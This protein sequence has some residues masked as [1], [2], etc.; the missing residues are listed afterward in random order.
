M[1]YSTQNNTENSTEQS[2]TE[3]TIDRKRS[4]SPLAWVLI[5]SG[6]FFALFLLVSGV[7]YVKKA[8]FRTNNGEEMA[9]ASSFF[10]GK[11][12]VGLIEMNGVI[13]DSKKTVAKLD[14]LEQDDRIKAVVLRLNSPG[15]AVGPSQEIYQAVKNFK[16]PLVV[17]MGTVAASGAY[18]IACGAKKVFANPGTLTGSIG[19]IMQFA[20]IQR[21]YDWA[22]I[23]R[24]SIKSGQFKD[25]GSEARKMTPEE[26]Q[27]FQNLVNDVLS[28]FK[29]AIVT[30]RSLTPAQVSAVAD[31]R[32]FS[33]NQAKEL[34][35]VDELGTLKDA[36]QEA[37]NQANIQ[38]RPEVITIEKP[39]R[40]ILDLFLD[41]ATETESGSSAESPLA[42]LGMILFRLSGHSAP[43]ALEFVPGLY[44]ILGSSGSGRPF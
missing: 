4:V 25:A 37:A 38:G 17:S 36:I 29:Q 7:L 35:L 5:L 13:M 9:S 42:Q 22:K 10:G 34:H 23:E 18:Y 11:S 40:G 33:G 32:V 30:G 28:Q 44:S 3:S 20:N 15:G 2:T 6:I 16:K 26:Q 24:Y 27:L 43:D 8:A 39:K 12:Y 14:K 1:P 21:L 41:D 19:V 31:G